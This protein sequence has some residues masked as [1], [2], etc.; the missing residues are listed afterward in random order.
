MRLLLPKALRS[1]KERTRWATGRVLPDGGFGLDVVVAGGEVEV[2]NT[3]PIDV[4]VTNPELGGG[5]GG[6]LT[7]QEP[8]TQTIISNGTFT[9][10]LNSE[11]ID[12]KKYNH[13]IIT[14][15][16]GTPTGTPTMSV[17]LNIKDTQENKFLHTTL[18]TIN[19]NTAILEEVFYLSAHTIQVECNRSL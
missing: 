13:V 12:F 3:N 10:T 8:L 1:F 5:A 18:P 6:T 11:D 17:K 9:E 2:K 7:P 19:S 4:N 14:V 15:K 16:T